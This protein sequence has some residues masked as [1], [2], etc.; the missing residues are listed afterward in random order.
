MAEADANHGLP[1]SAFILDQHV[2][3]ALD[4]SY[5]REFH[6]DAG[7]AEESAMDTAM[8]GNLGG[9]G[10]LPGGYETTTMP[11][12]SG[13]STPFV[14]PSSPLDFHSMAHIPQRSASDGMPFTSNVAQALCQPYDAQRAQTHSVQTGE[15]LCGGPLGT[16]NMTYDVVEPQERLQ[17]MMADTDL[18]GQ[19]SPSRK[20]RQSNGSTVVSESPRTSKRKTSASSAQGKK[21]DGKISTFLT[22]LYAIL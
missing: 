15:A 1:P 14:Y 5:N 2:Q 4:M 3:A 13:Q 7:H 12:L 22:K 16:N 11:F 9:A 10:N 8:L 19:Q 20:G 17:D 21:T 6:F 18:G